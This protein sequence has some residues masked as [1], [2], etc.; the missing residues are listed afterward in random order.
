MNILKIF[1]NP[2]IGYSLTIIMFIII[3]TIH[4]LSL[5]YIKPTETDTFENIGKFIAKL[6]INN[7]TE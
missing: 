7:E 1:I 4:I 6:I 5:G 2:I 3:L